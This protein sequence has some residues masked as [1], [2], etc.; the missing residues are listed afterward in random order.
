MKIDALR[1]KK[2]G[3][4]GQ[5]GDQGFD[6]CLLLNEKMSVLMEVKHGKNRCHRSIDV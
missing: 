1:A 5:V 6:P 4:L 3:I 2:S